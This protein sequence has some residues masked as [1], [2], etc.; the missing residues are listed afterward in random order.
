MLMAGHRPLQLGTFIAV[1][2]AVIQ[3]SLNRV[4]LPLLI[5]FAL[6]FMMNEDGA[7][8]SILSLRDLSIEV[9]PPLLQLRGG[10]FFIW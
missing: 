4:D 5:G 2:V 1:L 10:P 7:S 8:M 6:A 3:L 9:E